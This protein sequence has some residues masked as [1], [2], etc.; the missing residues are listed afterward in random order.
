MSRREIVQYFISLFIAVFAILYA[1]WLGANL[2]MGGESSF[3]FWVMM[4]MDLV[5]STCSTLATIYKADTINR[6]DNLEH[7]NQALIEAL[8]R[9]LSSEEC[10]ERIFKNLEA[11]VNFLNAYPEKITAL[12]SISGNELNVTLPDTMLRLLQEN[13]KLMVGSLRN[14]VCPSYTVF[15]NTMSL[16]IVCD[17]LDDHE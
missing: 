3:P 1:I 16:E 5:I 17:I 13:E 6:L 9:P 10:A 15:S 2:T 8:K 11:M 12:L 7:K 4:L 14:S